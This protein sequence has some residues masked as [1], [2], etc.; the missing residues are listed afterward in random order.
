MNLETKRFKEEIMV[1]IPKKLTPSMN[2]SLATP[3]IEGE[4]QVVVRAMDKGKAPSPN[5]IVADFFVN[6][7]ISL[8]VDYHGM[9]IR[10]IEAKR[11]LKRVTKRLITLLYRFGEK[12]DL[13]NWHP[14]SLYNGITQ[15]KTKKHPPSFLHTCDTHMWEKKGG[16]DNFLRHKIHDPTLNIIIS[17][18]WVYTQFEVKI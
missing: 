16:V 9:I 7:G 15:K 10:S 6:F 1:A 5:G 3:I 13:G 4:L 18:T 17:R 8:G 2:I 11:F 14:I 12:S